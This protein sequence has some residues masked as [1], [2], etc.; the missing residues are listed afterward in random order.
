MHCEPDHVT[1]QAFLELFDE[2]V[3]DQLKAKWEEADTHA[4]VCFTVQDM[5]SSQMGHRTALKVGPGCT[6]ECVKGVEDQHLGDVPSRFQYPTEYCLKEGVG[7]L[8]TKFSAAQRSLL[9]QVVARTLSLWDAHSQLENSL[10]GEIAGMDQ[11]IGVA[12]AT[13]DTADDFN[14][15]KHIDELL[16]ALEE[17]VV[18]DES[19]EP[20][21]P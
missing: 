13:I 1:F 14:N 3:H 7:Y 4:L 16:L 8:G 11:L 19:G 17:K 15:P 9:L 2:E 5:C 20:S 12:C 10:G 21:E 18:P 6:I